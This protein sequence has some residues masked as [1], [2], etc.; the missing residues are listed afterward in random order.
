MASSSSAAPA[1]DVPYARVCA[2]NSAPLSP[3]VSKASSG[4]VE[5]VSVHSVGV[6]HRFLAQCVEEGWD[7]FGAAAEDRA[8][9]VTEVDI[10]KP[11]VLVMGNEGSGL[12]T[13]VRRACNR[14]VRIQVGQRGLERKRVE[15][16]GLAHHVFSFFPSF[17][18]RSRPRL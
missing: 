17:E 14:M 9:D 2:K 18:N 16:S 15:T 1:L 13:N 12:R 7:V 11:S 3:V 5:A 4:A 8:E 10:S 6:M